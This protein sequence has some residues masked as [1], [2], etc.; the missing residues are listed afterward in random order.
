MMK[1]TEIAIKMETDAVKFYT[2]AAERV[3]SRAG[4]KMFLSIAEDEKRH[5]EMVKALINGMGISQDN[6]DPMK[7]V[8]TV[9]ESMKD[10]MQEKIAS[11]KE[12]SEALTIAMQMEK[13]GFEFYKKT[14]AEAT[15]ENSKTLFSRLVHEEEKHYEMFMNTLNFLNDTGNW[16]MWQEHSIVEGG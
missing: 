11:T 16:F 13:E 15:D 4:K 10:Q 3:S 7:K 14:A 1:A 8:I 9:F 6:V 12:D 5:I 2:E